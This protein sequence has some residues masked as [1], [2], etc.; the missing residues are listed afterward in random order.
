MDRNIGRYV[1]I[2][3]LHSGQTIDGYLTF[4]RLT[5]MTKQVVFAVDMQFM[6]SPRLKTESLYPA[7][8]SCLWGVL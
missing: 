4:Y 2:K 7:G 8:P 6:S 3:S 1:D 5:Y